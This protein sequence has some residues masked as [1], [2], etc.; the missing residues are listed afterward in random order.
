LI[1]HA[2]TCPLKPCA[3]WVLALRS[4]RNTCRNGTLPPRT[5]A[6]VSPRPHIRNLPATPESMPSKEVAE[7]RQGWGVVIT[8][9]YQPHRCGNG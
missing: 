2:A 8:P 3:A 5:T 7:L 6:L 4:E 1:R 9:P